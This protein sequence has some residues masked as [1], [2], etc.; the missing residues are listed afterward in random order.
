[1]GKARGK[2][3]IGKLAIGIRRGMGILCGTGILPVSIYFG[4]GYLNTGDREVVTTDASP[5]G[6]GVDYRT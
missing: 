2:L 4:A 3:A 5:M 1:M 6:I